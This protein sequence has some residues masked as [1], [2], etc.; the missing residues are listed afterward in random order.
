MCALV[1]RVPACSIVIV[2]ACGHPSSQAC[3]AFS[4]T[5]RYTNTRGQNTSPI[6]VS[7]LVCCFPP[8]TTLRVV[9]VLR[10]AVLYVGCFL[11]LLKSVRCQVPW[12]H[13]RAPSRHCRGVRQGGR[14]R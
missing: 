7:R 14:L 13:T 1:T 9:Q 10:C 11:L 8:R 4:V 2:W 5:L 12:V 3:G 6:V